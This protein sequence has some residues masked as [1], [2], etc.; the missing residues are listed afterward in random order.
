MAPAESTRA[1][2]ATVA[3]AVALTAVVVAAGALLLAAPAAPTAEHVGADASEEFAAVDG[4][5]ATRTTV[6][7]RGNRTSETV[8]DVALRPGT[9]LRRTELVTGDRSH[10][11]TASNGSVLWL[12]DADGEEVTRIPLSSTPAGESTT[13]DRVERL[14]AALN[15]TQPS[16]STSR[17][18]EGP[19][20]PLPIVP[21]T[22][23]AAE[24]PTA[25]NDSVAVSFD[26]TATVDGREAYVLRVEST[27]DSSAFE[28]RLWV[29]RKTFF[30]LQRQTSWTDGGTPV[31]VTTTYE[32][33]TV[34]PGLDAETFR[35]DPP[36]DLTVET[37][38]TPETTA[39]DSVADVRAATTAPVPTLDV[40]PSFRLTYATATDGRILGAG[41]RYANETALVTAATY[42]RTLPLEGERTTSVG[43][44]EA[45]VDVGP[46]TSVSWNC[47]DYRYTVRGQGVSVE[48][49]VELARSVD[50]G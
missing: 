24:A 10:E 8:V 12:Y 31:S 46:T 7:E 33:V 28:Q 19:I 37:P 2:A 40:P 25:T 3:L 27:G 50:C 39:F 29:D 20:S 38:E 11:V 30:P 17:T 48:F 1:S 43:D 35:F 44:H 5:T 34:N 16:E 6:V 49:L 15:V 47:G 14:F 9:D 45:V 41:V 42:N 36:S 22:S 32:N 13:G 23:T 26:G 21:E 4:L 18:M